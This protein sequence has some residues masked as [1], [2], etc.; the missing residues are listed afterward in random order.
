MARN[1]VCLAEIDVNDAKIDI[2]TEKM[3][4]R[5]RVHFLPEGPPPKFLSRR[6]WKFWITAGY[7][8]KQKRPF[9]HTLPKK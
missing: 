4:A 7:T 5:K 6:L 8:E 3:P 9:W 1:A 2:L